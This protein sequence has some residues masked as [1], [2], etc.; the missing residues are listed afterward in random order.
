MA[1]EFFNKELMDIVASMITVELAPYKI[2]IEQLEN[3]IANI[4]LRQ[5][6]AWDNLSERNR[7]ARDLLSRVEVTATREEMKDEIEQELER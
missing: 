6:E 2:K 1:K 7:R 5:A 3:E 4:K